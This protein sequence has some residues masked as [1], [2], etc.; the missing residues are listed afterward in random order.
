MNG[1]IETYLG[2]EVVD[3]EGTSFGILDCFW[4]YQES[5]PAFFGVKTAMNSTQTSI[6]PGELVE[7]NPSGLQVLTHRELVQHGPSLPCEEPI[8]P[9]FESALRDYYGTPQPVEIR[10]GNLR[11][12]VRQ[13]DPTC[14]MR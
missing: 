12:K 9:D 14:P 1:R 7:L 11:K 10:R 6:V 3:A 8:S 5:E 13:H 4:Y 2:S